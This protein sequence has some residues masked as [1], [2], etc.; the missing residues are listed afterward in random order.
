MRSLARKAGLRLTAIHADT[1]AGFPEVEEYV[2]S[3]CRKL[4][5]DLVVV[6]PERDYFDLAKRWGIPG[7]RSRWCCETLKIAPIR[8]YL[9]QV[10]GPKVIYD[11]IRAAESN[12]RATYLPIWYHP[13]F[14]TICASPIFYWSDNRVEHYIIQQGLPPNPTINMGTSGECW[15]GAYKCRADFEALLDVHPDIFEKLV[16]VEEAQ[17]GD[18]TFLYERGQRVPLNSLRQGK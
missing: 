16:K 2:G 18:F 12:L 7:V 11:G 1:T 5:V 17:R 6:R 14:K 10:E 3:V 8:R 13:A 4:G 15:C 9:A